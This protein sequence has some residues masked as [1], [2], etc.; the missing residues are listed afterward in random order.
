MKTK[1]IFKTLAFAMLMPAMMLT[2]ACSSE[3]DIVNTPE[4]TE[5]TTGK[6]YEIPITINATRQ[7][8]TTTRATYN[9]STNKLEFSEGDKLYVGGNH[10]TA[11][12][13]Y[14]TIEW[15]GGTTFSGTITTTNPYSGTGVELLSSASAAGAVLLPAGYTDYD[16]L[17]FEGL[18]L[19]S[20]YTKALAPSKAKA[21]EQFS[22][23]MATTYSN[24]FALAPQSAILNFTITGLTKNSTDVDVILTRYDETLC[25]GKVTTD[26]SG[27][28]TFAIGIRTNLISDFHHCILTVGGND[29]TLNSSKTFEIGHI[30]NIN[31][32]VATPMNG[33]F[34]VSA[35]TKVYFS[36]GNL[37]ATWTFSDAWNWHFAENQ[38]DY[39]GNADGNTVVTNNYPYVSDINS[40]HTVDLFG[41]VGASSGFTEAVAMYGITSSDNEDDYGNV[42]GEALKTDWGNTMSRS[43][44]DYTGASKTRWRTL[45]RSEWYYVFFQR[46]TTSGVLFVK[47]TVNGVNGV[48]LMPDDWDTSY[49]SPN[50][51]NGPSASFDTNVITS[52]VWSS[53]FAAHGCVFLPAAGYRSEST[54]Y[55]AGS[56]G[57]YWSSSSLLT[58]DPNSN[59]KYAHMLFIHPYIVDPASESSYS[60]RS[61][62]YSVRL[63]RDVE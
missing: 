6:G 47:A 53:N 26:G 12:L 51:I 63:V 39:I 25:S 8:A 16:F 48:I 45:T 34:S 60:P 14:G 62:G 32:S 38:W 31:K 4:K 22:Y 3:D 17:K 50:S 43:W 20:D 58:P 54:V 57:Y 23:E 35:N 44:M 40:S 36:S 18:K 29:I 27:T 61:Q 52:E 37:Q 24:G 5:N 7:D 11:G 9:S 28:A 30:Y 15:K 56:R 1:N 2:T 55:E 49:A 46:N 10:S 33:K 21:V 59:T 41:W 42:F 19:M 13:F